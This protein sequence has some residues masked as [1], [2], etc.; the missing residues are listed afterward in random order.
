MYIPNTV[1]GM[2]GFKHVVFIFSFCLI[3][4][5]V[6]PCYI[7][8]NDKLDSFFITLPIVLWFDFN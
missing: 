4:S 7:K 5:H 8:L 2:P 1:S 3:N 6:D